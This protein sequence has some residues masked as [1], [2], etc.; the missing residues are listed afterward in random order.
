MNPVFFDTNTF[1]DVDAFIGLPK[2]FYTGLLVGKQEL[3]DILND[4]TLC[5]AFF[6]LVW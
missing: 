4:K 2:C 5:K 3:M 6:E 1:E